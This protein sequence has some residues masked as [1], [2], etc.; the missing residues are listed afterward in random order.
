MERI[1]GIVWTLLRVVA[2]VLFA[3]HG[4]QKLFGWFG[5][6][7]MTGKPLLLAA[8]VIGAGVWSVDAMRHPVAGVAPLHPRVQGT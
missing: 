7:P 4:G 8:A 2:G 1:P 5:T 6:P 3:S